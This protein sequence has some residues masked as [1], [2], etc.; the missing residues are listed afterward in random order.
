MNLFDVHLYRIRNILIDRIETKASDKVINIL[1][2]GVYMSLIDANAVGPDDDVDI[3]TN[4]GNVNIMMEGL[5]TI[6]TFKSDGTIDN[7]LDIDTNGADINI[8]DLNGNKVYT[9]DTIIHSSEPL[10]LYPDTIVRG[11]NVIIIAEKT[12]IGEIITVEPSVDK[13]SGEIIKKGSLNISAVGGIAFETLNVIDGKVILSAIGDILFD[14]ITATRSELDFSTKSKISAFK[15]E[16]PHITYDVD[17]TDANA[18]LT[19][20]AGSVGEETKHLIVDIPEVLTMHIPDADLV[21]VDAFDK[22]ADPVIPDTEGRDK[23]GNTI[24]GDLYS[25][26]DDH[27]TDS[28]SYVLDDQTPAELAKLFVEGEMDHDKFIGILQDKIEDPKAAGNGTGTGAGTPEPTTAKLAVDM[29]MEKIGKIGLSN[30]DKEA[31][32]ALEADN[33]KTLDEKRYDFCRYPWYKGR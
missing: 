1:V 27:K 30:A 6:G 13:D 10:K 19:L 15:T 20:S 9:V 23:D 3:K 17:D 28:F 26:Y 7:E 2:E 14:T 22:N 24:S 11:A 18:K 4:G 8:M 29:L 25:G 21:F 16:N 31:Y 5:G 12:V 33:N 32:E